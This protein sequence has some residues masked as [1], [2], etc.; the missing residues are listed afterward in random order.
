MAA[1]ELGK[2]QSSGR[3]GYGEEANVCGK[4]L[5]SGQATQVLV[6]CPDQSLPLRLS[7]VT[8]FMVYSRC[9]GIRLKWHMLCGLLIHLRHDLQKSTVTMSGAEPI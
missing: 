6:G 1:L 7:K 4:W 8:S 2:C 3:Q 5:V 9:T